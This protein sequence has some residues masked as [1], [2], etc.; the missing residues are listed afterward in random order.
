MHIYGKAGQY[1]HAGQRGKVLAIGKIIIK[2]LY[3]A[4]SCN[5]QNKTN[6][7]EKRAVLVF[8]KSRVS[9]LQLFIIGI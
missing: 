4:N 7:H 2:K 1:G 9:L 8:L 5:C 6:F 3:L